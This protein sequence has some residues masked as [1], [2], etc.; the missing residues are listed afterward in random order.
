MDVLVGEVEGGNRLRNI[1]GNRSMSATGATI[2]RGEFVA[3]LLHIS[4]GMMDVALE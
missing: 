4:C 1:P 2:P 3:V